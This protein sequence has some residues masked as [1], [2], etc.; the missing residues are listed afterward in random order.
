MSRGPLD[1]MSAS[2][3]EGGGRPA[4]PDSAKHKKQPQHHHISDDLQALAIALSPLWLAI[5]LAI[6]LRGA[7]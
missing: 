5:L 2:D 6:Y 3:S 1:P 7:S 4:A